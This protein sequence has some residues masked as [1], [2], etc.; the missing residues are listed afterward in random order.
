MSRNQPKPRRLRKLLV[1][2]AIAGALVLAVLYATCG[3]GFGVGGGG[4][5]G[6]SPGSGS[7]TGTGAAARTDAAPP[8]CALRVDAAGVHVD[9]KLVDEAA[10]IAA[11]KP[12]GA[13]DVLV[14]GD[15]VQGT[16]DHLRAALDAAG[17]ATFVRGAPPLPDAGV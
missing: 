5:V 7:G 2:A 14:T 8:R 13:A 12:A 15:A 9:G 10:A 6:L 17:I 3:H 4:G 11:C 16:W 1:L